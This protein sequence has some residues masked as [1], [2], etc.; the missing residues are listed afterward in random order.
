[1]GVSINKLEK[2]LEPVYK[3]LP[4]LPKNVNDWF[5]KAW[6]ILTLIVGILQLLAACS[7]W[8]VGHVVNSLVTY[9]NALAN[10]YGTAATV[11]HLGFFYWLSLIFLAIDGII[12]IIAYPGLKARRKAGWDMLFLGAVVNVV[13]GIVSVFDNTYGGIGK[14]VLTL[15]GSAVGFYFLFQVRSYYV[16]KA[17]TTLSTHSPAKP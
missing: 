6:P 17:K 15:I 5:A 3:A 8:H 11:N 9:T 14:L 16:G 4:P 2:M 7:L 13:Y 1:M 10:M 12:F